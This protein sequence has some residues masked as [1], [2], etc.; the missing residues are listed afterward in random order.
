[1]RTQEREERTDIVLQWFQDCLSGKSGISKGNQWE[2]K[3][4]QSSRCWLALQNTGLQR[5]IFQG[6]I[7]HKN[8]KNGLK[9]IQIVRTNNQI[10]ENMKLKRSETDTSTKNKQMETISIKNKRWS[11][12]KKTCDL[13]TTE[14]RLD[15]FVQNERCEKWV[16]S[17]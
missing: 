5:L 15:C 14:T 8:E 17:T 16:E 6:A 4:N 9:I 3:K 12:R 10:K 11:R 2:T 13:A 1:M 7:T